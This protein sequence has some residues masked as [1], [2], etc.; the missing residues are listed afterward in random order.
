MTSPQRFSLN[1]VTVAVIVLVGAAGFGLGLM[2]HG[3]DDAKAPAE[4]RAPASAAS[5]AKAA[6]DELKIPPEYIA[7]A[8]IAVE[9]ATSAD[10]HSELLLPAVVVAAPG[11]E[12]VVTPRATG[13]LTRVTHRLGDSVKAG[14]VLAT[15]ESIDAATMLSERR[16]AQARADLA[17]KA[18]A[19]EQSLFE[20]GVTPRQ[21]MEAARAEADVAEA[22]AQ[23]ALAVTRAARVADDG[24]TITIASPIAGRITAA[25]AMT[26]GHVTPD[27]EVFRVALPGAVQVE[28]PVT[29]DDLRRIVVGDAATLLLRSGAPVRAKVRSLTPTVSATS[30]A[31]TA[32]LVPES[33]QDA[34][35][36][37]SG[38]GVQVRLHARSNDVPG[39]AV[40]ED[41]VQNLDGHDVVYLRT[42][43]GFRAQPVFVGNRSHGMAQVVNGLQAGQQVATRNAFLLKA[44]SRKP[45]GEEE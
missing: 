20:Q 13:T 8:A 3:G 15:V 39:V 11:A 40:P 38:E 31:A 36:L 5:S 6:D 17:R 16:V 34:A 45:Q 10:V 42:E 41:A 37:V 33:P 23:R 14:E 29:A 18:L 19:R 43:Q 24:R 25:S 21:A 4:A 27:T 32:V 35:A 26:G 44:E 1:A 2:R 30:R 22:E 9:A 7:A 12:A 28:A